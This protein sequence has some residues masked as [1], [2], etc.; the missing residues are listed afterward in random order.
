M[1]SLV[2]L[3]ISKTEP[4]MKIF[5]QPF[6]DIANELSSKGFTWNSNGIE[7]VSKLFPLGCCVDSVARCAILNMKKFN[8]TYGCTYCEHPTVR[9]QGVRKYPMMENVSPLRTDDS[10]KSSMF[11]AHLN[12]S[13]DIMGVWG[14]SPL[15]NLR[16]FTITKGMVVDYMHSC[17]LG[18]AEMH[19]TLLLSNVGTEY[20]VGS[21]A[22]IHLIDERLLSIKPPSCIGKLPRSITE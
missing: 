16:H 13:K 19:L 9:I 15:I 6:V 14:P 22:E 1:Y 10:I 11:E 20:Y 4:D 5:L 18:V 17:L 2:G 3:W 7:V 12:N 8:G 21:P